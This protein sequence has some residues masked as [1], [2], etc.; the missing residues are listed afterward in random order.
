MTLSKNANQIK[1]KF[2]RNSL[3][4][5]QITFYCN[6]GNVVRSMQQALKQIKK[7]SPKQKSG[8]CDG[9]DLKKNQGSTSST[10]KLKY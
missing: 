2:F 10:K 8:I 6:Y 1:L 4:E 9:S 3:S 5:V 7:A